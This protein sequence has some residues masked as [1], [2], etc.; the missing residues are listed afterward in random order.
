MTKP[1]NLEAFLATL[2]WTKHSCLTNKKKVKIIIKNNKYF[3]S[4][5]VI[6]FVVVSEINKK[7]EGYYGNLIAWVMMKWEVKDKEWEGKEAYKCCSLRFQRLR[8]TLS[9]FSF[10]PQFFRFP[11]PQDIVLCPQNQFLHADLLPSALR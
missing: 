7:F 4:T 10:I 5:T 3:Y 8:S 2:L 1:R 6:H 11:L 9:R